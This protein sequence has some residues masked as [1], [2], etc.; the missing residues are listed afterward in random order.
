MRK[1]LFLA[2]AQR[3]SDFALL[4]LRV[5][6]GLSFA[7]TAWSTLDNAPKMLDLVSDLKRMGVPN[8]KLSALILSYVALAVGAAF[9]LGFLTRWAGIICVLIFVVTIATFSSHEGMRAV[10][11]PGA[12]AFIGLYLATYGGGR[13]SV[14]AALRA[15]ESPRTA[16]GVRL[17]K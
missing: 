16:A 4:L 14:D 12:Y 6:V 2:A 11:L 3:F 5:F 7:V 10:F 17:K 15:N 1:F 13:F 9:V 8:A